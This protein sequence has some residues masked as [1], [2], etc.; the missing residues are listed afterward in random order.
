MFANIHGVNISNQLAKILKIEQLVL[1]S[2]SESVSVP[3]AMLPCFLND[4]LLNVA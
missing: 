4:K 3:L 2:P 1:T